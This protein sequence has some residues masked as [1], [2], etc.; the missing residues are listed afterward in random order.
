MGN[1]HVSI[2][3]IENGDH[4]TFDLFT[5]KITLLSGD[6]H[7]ESVRDPIQCFDAVFQEESFRLMGFQA[8]CSKL[9]YPLPH[10]T[11]C[12]SVDRR[13]EKRIL[14]FVN[15]YIIF[16]FDEDESPSGFM[17]NPLPFAQRSFRKAAFDSIL[18]KRGKT[19]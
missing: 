6:F 2:C 19:E 8:D 10:E 4:R 16:V 3:H 17:E 18:V 13:S 11:V 5:E 15:R 12:L 1:I 7:K 14:S 9:Q